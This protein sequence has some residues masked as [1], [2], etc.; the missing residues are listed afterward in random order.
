MSATETG[1]TSA[2]HIAQANAAPQA[3]AINAVHSRAAGRPPDAAAEPA[4]TDRVGRLWRQFMDKVMLS[5]RCV[6]SR[7]GDPIRSPSNSRKNR[8][9]PWMGKAHGAF[10]PRL[11]EVRCHRGKVT[12]RT[13][14]LTGRLTPGPTRPK[15]C[16]KQ[17]MTL[18]GDFRPRWPP[19]RPAL[20]EWLRRDRRGR[21][22]CVR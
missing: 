18:E 6:A 21:S 11:F 22:R 16:V 19:T 3:P 7:P 13:V 15:R 1:P 20:I 9:S 10:R 2:G 17:K 12:K 14:P 4:L 5:W 8:R